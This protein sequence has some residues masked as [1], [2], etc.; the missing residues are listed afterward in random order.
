[1]RTMDRLALGAFTVCLAVSLMG[2]KGKPEPPKV[3]MR[4]EPGA[5][6]MTAAMPVVEA[7]NAFGLKLLDL[8]AQ[9]ADK[10]NVLISP[11]SLQMC[12]ALLLESAKGPERD[13]MKK[14]LGLEAVSDADMGL[15]FKTLSDALLSDP[16]RPLNLANAV[17]L[18]VPVSVERPFADRIAKRYD[19]EIRAS[20]GRDE[21]LAAINDWVDKKTNGMIPTLLDRVDPGELVIMLNAVAFE[22]RW[23]H[24][25]KEED[26]RVKPFTTPSGGDV[27]ASLMTGEFDGAE[28]QEEEYA[29]VRMHYL[30]R[31]FSM[32]A[33][34][35]PQGKTP[36]DVLQTI[37]KRGFAEVLKTFHG[38]EVWLQFPKF[39]WEDDH[40]LN[41]ALQALGVRKAYQHLD[42]SPLS[43][44]LAKGMFLSR[45]LQKTLIEVD[46]RGTRAAAA[47]AAPAAGGSPIVLEFNR[48]FL[49]AIVHNQTGVILFLGICGDPTLKQ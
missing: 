40:K 37:R 3:A 29:G 26:T 46:E 14:A 43:P 17:W 35:P 15:H 20:N 6:R 11:L 21:A 32:A 13:E 36:L 24:E 23:Q 8:V 12:A 28:A 27:Q 5:E 33:F 18:T 47:T 31:K 34:L 48:P 22:A 25:F 16:E 4:P 45:I 7:S 38:S 9:R 39:R 49:Y 42:L 1:M 44:Q 30:G 10:P 2:C 41:K 19:G